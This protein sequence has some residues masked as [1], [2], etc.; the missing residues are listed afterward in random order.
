MRKVVVAYHIIRLTNP[1]HE[2]FE[3]ICRKMLLDCEG[4]L[5]KNGGGEPTKVHVFVT[6]DWKTDVFEIFQ[7]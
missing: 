3:D 7:F 2:L 6:E 5:L 1:H 4:G